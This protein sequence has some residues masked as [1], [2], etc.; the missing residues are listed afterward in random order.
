M[1]RGRQLSKVITIVTLLNGRD[2]EKRAAQSKAIDNEAL[3]RGSTT[4]KSIKYR[5]E[6]K[7]LKYLFVQ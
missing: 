2:E 6:E 7:L 3:D 4:N 1:Y 5:E